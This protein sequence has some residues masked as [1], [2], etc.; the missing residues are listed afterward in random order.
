MRVAQDR[1]RIARDD[2]RY[3]GTREQAQPKRGGTAA[4]SGWGTNRRTKPSRAGDCPLCAQPW[5][6][7]A[8]RACRRKVW[9][10]VPA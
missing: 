1:E 2:P 7:A 6:S 10:G 4:L 8:H 3:K 5:D 9:K